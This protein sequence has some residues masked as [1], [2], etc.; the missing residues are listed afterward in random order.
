MSTTKCY[1]VHPFIL[2]I[3]PN[4]I[5]F[6]PN[7]I[8]ECDDDSDG[9]LIVDLSQQSQSILNGQD[10]NQ[11]LISYF[12]TELDAL[13]NI[14]QLETDYLASNNDIIY[15]RVDHIETECFDITSFEIEINSLPFASIEDQVLC[16][17]NLPLV[18][19][20]ETNISGDTYLW[21]TNETTAAIEITETGTYSVTVTNAFGCSK[22]STFNVT[23]SESATID[24]I[25]TIDF[26]DPNNITITVQYFS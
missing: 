15:A 23:E 12:I 9:L 6:P 19:S 5:A 25:E 21:S 8:E 7:N 18:V 3:V 20:A 4:P 2:N 26:S 22:T 16:L 1:T 24:F 17:N 13:E 11:N 10:P 14:N